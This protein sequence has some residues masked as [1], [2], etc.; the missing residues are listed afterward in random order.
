M[1]AAD[2]RSVS[3][4]AQTDPW[5]P[6][7]EIE[8]CIEKGLVENPPKF[9]GSCIQIRLFSFDQLRRKLLLAV[10]WGR[11]TDRKF[12]NLDPLLRKRYP[13][14]AYWF[15]ALT[16]GAVVLAADNKIFLS[17]RSNEVDLSKGR[18]D[19][20]CGHP[21]GLREMPSGSTFISQVIKDVVF[22]ETG[23]V[24]MKGLHPLVLLQEFPHNDFDLIYVV[25]VAESGSQLATQ[26]PG[27]KP[28]FLL[29]ANPDK[30]TRFLQDNRENMS[31][32]TAA[33]LLLF[34]ARAFGQE[35]FETEIVRLEGTIA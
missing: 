35:W 24:H 29:E 1:I 7:P 32:P 14:P 10:G 30:V 15:N 25:R 28:V 12:T 23:N 17:R 34:G 3:I 4:E 2:I 9:N 21:S 13:E 27:N 5:R 26:A 6:E 11:F 8:E 31:R 22:R 18:I 20:P 33:A 19:I 16:P